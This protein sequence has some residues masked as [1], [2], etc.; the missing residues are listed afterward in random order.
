MTFVETEQLIDDLLVWADL[1]DTPKRDLEERLLF[2]VTDTVSPDANTLRTRTEIFEDYQEAVRKE[3]YS[4]SLEL[5]QRFFDYET[6]PLA[7]GSSANRG[8]RQ[9]ALLNLA[10]FHLSHEDFQAARIAANEGLKIARQTSDLVT[11]NAL[12]SVLKKISFEDSSE[13]LEYRDGGHG[14]TS[15][16]EAGKEDFGGYVPPMDYLWDVRFGTSTVSC[17]HLMLVGLREHKSI[18]TS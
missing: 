8:M 14:D 3:D 10:Q 5:L 4:Q 17:Q 2:S 12:T 16:A 18:L 13:R 9:H 6:F 1:S 15:V 11:L 7:G